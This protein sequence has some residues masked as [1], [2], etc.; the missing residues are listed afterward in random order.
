MPAPV[1]KV[2]P[3]NERYEVSDHGFVRN[4]KTKRVLRMYLVDGYFRLTLGGG[5]KR[6]KKNFLVS[7]LVLLT[8][9]GRCDDMTKDQ[10][11]HVNGNRVDN[12]LENLTWKDHAGNHEDRVKHGNVLNGEAHPN[13]KLT[14]EKV[15]LMRNQYANGASQKELSERFCVCRAHVSNIVNGARWRT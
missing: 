2:C 9:V 13:A 15:C 8:F 5:G 14:T 3:F 4:F 1:W 12:R 11:A 6:V 10:C 7:R